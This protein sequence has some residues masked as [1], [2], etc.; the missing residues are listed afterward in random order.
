MSFWDR[1]AR[2]Y[3]FTEI[4]NGRVYREM[5]R[6][7]RQVV[8][9][10]AKVL[11]CA[12]GTGKLTVAAAEKAESVLCTDLSMPMLEQAR[13]KCEK[14]GLRNVSFEER[15]ISD[16]PE[17]DNTYDAVIAGNVL[18]LLDNPQ[19]AVRELYRVTKVGGRLIFPTFLLNRNGK[20]TFWIRLY[21]LVGFN[22]STHYSREDYLNMLEGCN[23]GRVKLT[24]INGIMPVGFAVMKKELQ[25]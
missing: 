15:N 13:R 16:M 22:P 8:P 18:H 20:L 1:I 14:A 3:D 7:I 17:S 25:K 21:K 10:G 12:A 23:C 4:V 5:Q 19:D 11:E 24:M 2:L 6:G 9:E